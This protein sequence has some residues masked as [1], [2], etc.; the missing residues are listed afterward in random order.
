MLI[1]VAVFIAGFIGFFN[2]EKNKLLQAVKDFAKQHRNLLERVVELHSNRTESLARDYSLWDEMVSFIEIRDTNWAN[3]NLKN[4]LTNF[5]THHE[6]VYTPE[7]ELIYYTHDNKRKD[8]RNVLPKK[9]Q[10]KDILK[11]DPFLHFYIKTNDGLIEV[12]GA[13]IQPITDKNRTSVPKGWF[14][15]GRTWSEDIL[16]EMSEMTYSTLQLDTSSLIT[17]RS[18]IIEKPSALV[19]AN[20]VFK[21]WSGRPIGVLRSVASFPFLNEYKIGSRYFVYISVFFGIVLLVVI[22]ILFFR[23]VEIPLR[24]LNKTLEMRDMRYIEPLKNYRTEFGRLTR[25]I[26]SVFEKEELL[27]ETEKRRQLESELRRS[28]QRFHLLV[29]NLPDILWIADKQGDTIY[30]SSNIYQVLG[31]KPDELI[32]NQNFWKENIHSDDYQKV[33]SR[34]SEFVKNNDQFDVEYRLKHKNGQI[35]WISEKA[36]SKFEH[37]G[38]QF[39][40]GRISDITK[41][42]QI[43]LRLYESEQHFRSLFEQNPF[44]V[45]ILGIKDHRIL[46]TN[47]AL[48]QMLGYS[49]NELIGLSV[50]SITPSDDFEKE[51]R[52]ATESVRSGI[53]VFTVE[54]RLYKKDGDL[55][56]VNLTGSY[57]FDEKGTHKYGFGIIENI[58]EKKSIQDHLT[59]EHTLLVSLMENV[60]DLIFF[61]DK[62]G[63][64]INANQSALQ[65]FEAMGYPDPI[66]LTD[67]EILNQQEYLEEIQNDDASILA[68]GKSIINK[69]EKIT[70]PSDETIWFSVTKFPILSPD[71]KSDILVGILRN[72]TERIENEL[73]LKKYAQE[74]KELNYSK[75]KFLSILAH[76]L[77]NP[78]N[79]ILG[80]ASVL[81]EEYNE[82]TDQERVHFIRN[83]QQAAENTFS[84]IQN[85]LEWSRSQTGRINFKPD[86]LDL[87]NII[88]ESVKLLKPLM[89]EKGGKVV[90]KIQYNTMVYVDENMMKTVFRNLISNAI[91]FSPK[92][93]TVTVSAR[94]LNYNMLE[95]TVEDEG[96]GIPEEALGRLF[97]IDDSYRREGTE[98][99]QGTGLGLILCK[100]F[101]EKHGGLIWVRSKEDQGTSFMLT[102][103]VE[104][105]EIRNIN[106]IES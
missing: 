66:G 45:A 30:Y 9:D 28:E 40:C 96:I 98:G 70:L 16:K 62:Q 75:D 5:K 21:G 26:K 61:K 52:A 73:K 57:I 34:Y 58:T 63:K 105:I 83:I 2:W 51:I 101:V 90:S 102:I 38:V 1:I 78:F 93:S 43:E 29:E 53:G 79:A 35:L 88:N 18:D 82:Y 47:S 22:S 32:D 8:I 23:F 91:K 17:D 103:P 97:K 27:Q 39:C 64:Y 84:L 68:S 99:E 13:P 95:V 87:S 4:T 92:K 19:H 59:R 42:K 50:E 14:F 72:I 33:M 106:E 37:D 20:Y 85:I 11:E 104:P 71:G 7:F 10:L 46:R 77:K 6:W 86:T 54:K 81:A 94:S 100:E 60:P 36:I 67:F 25:S 31:Y 3:N 41:E 49:E 55:I 24:Y 65:F 89:E 74:L 80:F 15:A 44:G 48:C 76:D 56:W 69:V 12:F